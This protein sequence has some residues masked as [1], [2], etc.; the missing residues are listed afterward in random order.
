MDKIRGGYYIKARCIQD[1]EIAHAPP[2]VREIWDWLIKEAN[3]VETKTNG[4]VLKRG[5]TLRSYKDIQ[6]G[7]SWKIGWRT[8]QYMKGD[9]ETGIKWLKQRTMITTVKTTRGMIVTV[10]NY[11]TYQLPENY[12]T[13]KETDKE[14]DSEPTVNRQRSIQ[15]R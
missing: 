4:I 1:S 14:T 7:L 11:D 15:E 3:H 12:E 2:H 5:Q 10:C 9:I 13:D 6:A 8:K